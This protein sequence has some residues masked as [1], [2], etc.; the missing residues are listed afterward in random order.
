MKKI[1][2][3]SIIGILIL[4]GYGAVAFSNEEFDD[5]HISSTVFFSEPK[6]IEKDGLLEINLI[7]ST[8]NL[9]NT[10]E[11]K[12]PA[13][14]KVFEIPYTSKVKSVEVVFSEIK[15][16][17]ISKK[18]SLASESIQDIYSQ[19][20]ETSLNKESEL[21]TFPLDLFPKER[22]TFNIGAGRSG[23]NLVNYLSVKLFPV[24]YDSSDDILYY[25]DNAEIN[26][27]YLPPANPITI[28]DEYDLLIITPTDFA[29]DLE[30]LVTHKNSYNVQT[31]M[32]TLSEIYN[33]DY[34]EVDGRDDPEKVKYFIKSAFDEW[35]IKYVLLVGGRNGG[36][37]EEKWWCPIR[38]SNMD[39][40]GED[41]FL[42][43]LYYSDIYDSEGNFSSWDTDGDLEFSE[44]TFTSRDVPEMYPD[45]YVGRL[46]CRA[47]F[48]VTIMVNKIITYENE[49]YGSDWFY[50]FVGVAG[51]T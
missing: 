10:D 47:N 25:S 31:K 17:K 12:L 41:T 18:I 51:D 45:V 46:A 19:N 48:E 4:S 6:L 3:I 22:Y 21:Q 32:V 26:I 29:S 42:C 37:S 44:W 13:V 35:G 28:A 5:F 8:S 14:T 38:Y 20:V 9:M 39:D 15:E 7:E 24:Q 1:I 49:A 34:F 43:D 2:S 27:N 36:I 30:P 16:K 33:G 50:K 40:G 11:Y 23:D